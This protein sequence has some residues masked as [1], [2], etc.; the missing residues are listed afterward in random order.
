MSKPTTEL[1]NKQLHQRHSVM[2]EGGNVPRAK[3]MDQQPVDRLLMNGMITLAQHQ[4]A[5]YLMELASRAHIYAKAPDPDAVRGGMKDYVPGGVIPFGNTLKIVERR[6]GPMHAYVVE[7]VV[8]HGWDISEREE[9]VDVLKEGLQIIADRRM[10]GGK[11]PVRHL[12][13][14]K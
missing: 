9:M 5:E 14:Q 6:Y 12:T 1:G 7:E 8:C 13:S 2:I 3:V 4:A 10:S 11:N